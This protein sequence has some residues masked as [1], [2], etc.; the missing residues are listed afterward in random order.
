LIDFITIKAEKILKET[1]D[2]YSEKEG[3]EMRKAEI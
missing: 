3:F 1:A 2:A